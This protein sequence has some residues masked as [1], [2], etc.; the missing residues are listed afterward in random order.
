MNPHRLSTILALLVAAIFLTGCSSVS[1]RKVIDLTPF[2]HIYVVHRLTDDHHIDDLFVR[3][4]QSRGHDASSGPL[5]MMPE[6]ADAVL[7]YADRWEWDFKSYLIELDV[8]LRTAHTDK[9]LADGRYYQPTIKTKPPAEAIHEL[10]GSLM[11]AAG[12]S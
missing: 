10:L 8:E 7:T 2:K 9:K 11:P 3:E 5:T 4:L 12:H 1:S 6:N